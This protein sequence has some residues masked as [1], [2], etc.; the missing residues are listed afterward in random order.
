ME[1]RG[2]SIISSFDVNAFAPIDSRLVA[3]SSSIRES[4]TYKYAGLKVYQT[5]V[6]KTYVWNGATWSQEGNG[7]YGGSGS[8]IGDTTVNM[9]TIGD[10]FGDQS[11]T[12]GFKTT[13]SSG[14]STVVDKFL[15]NTSGTNYQGVE[16]RRQYFYNNNPG[17]Y[18]SLNSKST[19]LNTIEFG[20]GNGLNTKRLSIPSDST[21]IQIWNPTYSATLNVSLLSSNRTYNL[22]NNSGT[23]ALIED[24]AAAYP[25]LQAV[26]TA[27]SS[28]TAGISIYSG[29]SFSVLRS[30]TNKVVSIIKDGEIAV[31]TD[32][33][34]NGWGV[35]LASTDTGSSNNAIIFKHGLYQSKIMAATISG[36]REIRFP[37]AT[38]TVALLSDLSIASTTT[39]WRYY[40]S[41]STTVNVPAKNYYVVVTNATGGTIILPS[42]SGVS[43]TGTSIL[44]ELRAGTWSINSINGLTVGSLT[45]GQFIRVISDGTYWQRW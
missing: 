38:G 27:G 10:N 20:V 13:P 32:Y 31:S 25:T 3:T 7:I 2:I 18:I 40:T 30:S 28:T 29:A 39:A 34:G 15:R 36:Y 21:G 42:A 23:I 35:S 43:T 17:A 11:Y 33:F 19:L 1:N 44:I 8:L 4:I 9:G 41:S 16:Y 22:P 24:I 14:S 5:D 12:F 6:N 45:S 37:D 26:T